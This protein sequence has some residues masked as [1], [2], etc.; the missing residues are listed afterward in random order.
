MA[1]TRRSVSGA[2]LTA[3]AGMIDPGG[4]RWLGKLRAII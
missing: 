1:A 2:V 4:L 3:E